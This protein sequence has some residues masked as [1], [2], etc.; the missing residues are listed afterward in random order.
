MSSPDLTKL[1]ESLCR[2]I[3][4]TPPHNPDFIFL[5]VVNP[6]PNG[7]W[8]GIDYADKSPS[9]WSPRQHLLT[10]QM[11]AMRA[12]NHGDVEARAGALS[13]L[14]WW[15][16]HDPVSLNWWHNQI[17]TPRLLAHSLLLIREHVPP[18]MLAASRRIFDRA[19][20]FFLLEDAVTRRPMIWTGANR[21]WISAN[22]LLAGALLDDEILIT[23]ALATAMQEIRISPRTEEGIQ[24]DAS[25]HQ[26]GPLLYNGGYGAAFLNECLF[27][28]QSTHGTRWE[29]APAYH[30]LL[31]D[32]LLD[33][34]RWMLRGADFNPGCR[35]R[36][37]T[38]PRQ[39]ST[40]LAPLATFLVEAGGPRRDE[41]QDISVSLRTHAAPGSL[42][43]NRMFYRSDF[44]VQQEV[45]ACLSVRMHSTRTVRA[46][47]CNDEGKRSHHVADGLTYL[48][49]TGAEYQDIF[50]VWDWQKLP[51]ITCLLTPKPE[52]SQTVWGRGAATAVGGVSDGKHGACMQH[53]LSEHLDARKSWFF[54]PEGLVCLGAGIRSSCTGPVVTTLDQS[55]RQGAVES[56]AQSSP[57]DDGRTTLTGARWLRH[58]P[59]GFVFPQ[60]ADV[61]LELGLKTGAWNLI[62]CGSGEPVSQDVFLA[63]LNHGG[64]P[65]NA[66][67][68][69]LITTE[70][71]RAALTRLVAKSPF[72]IMANTETCQA[73]WWPESRLLQAAFFQPGELALSDVGSLR[74]NRVCCVQLREESPGSWQLNI[75]DVQQESGSVSVEF[76]EKAG[77]VTK[78]ATAVFPSGDH[79]GETI[80]GSW[81]I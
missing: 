65:E 54:G 25:F 48:Q 79:A 19:G 80:R 51:G 22:R 63:S 4:A 8:A 58:G 77:A 57:L 40:A 49:R 30:N 52:S 46:E 53:L 18:S 76:R 41:L 70:A 10:T 12:F 11:L 29:P 31:A 44:M 16:E 72:E 2:R 59:W 39:T 74:V 78:T 50:P 61:T 23:D 7:T 60:P 33:G 28:L 9:I 81:K 32:F 5:S 67:Y 55:L 71:D 75:A 62:G 27:F 1:R 26:H 21:L 35:D 24:V 14:G 37:I 34:T 69:Y 64:K 6:A 45:N 38:R 68:A 43:G 15:I 13:A 56:D 36:E 66:T 42:T 20:D 17:G 73:V 3:A 47:L